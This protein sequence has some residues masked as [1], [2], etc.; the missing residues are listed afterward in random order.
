MCLGI[1]NVTTTL[2]NTVTN[3]E[4]LEE[5]QKPKRNF[6]KIISSKTSLLLLIYSTIHAVKQNEG[7]GK[8]NHSTMCD[9][10]TVC[11]FETPQETHSLTCCPVLMTSLHP[12]YFSL[13]ADIVR[14]KCSP[15]NFVGQT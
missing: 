13:R 10:V 2:Y 3:P 5:S 7:L 8:G 12:S 14:R 15:R 11:D 9:N 1:S 6:F 4:L